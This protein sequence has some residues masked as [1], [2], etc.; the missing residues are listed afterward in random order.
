VSVL[1]GFLRFNPEAGLPAGLHAESIADRIGS[2]QVVG[3]HGDDGLPSPH[4]GCAI[5]DPVYLL[6]IVVDQIHAAG[7]EP[8][9]VLYPAGRLFDV[10]RWPEGKPLFGTHHRILYLFTGD[11]GI[12]TCMC[13]L[14]S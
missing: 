9:V 12:L 13:K 14:E 5:A 10:Q 11:K 3:C 2:D 8:L 6:K 4:A 1:Q 7:I